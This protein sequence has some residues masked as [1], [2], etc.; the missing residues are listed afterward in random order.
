MRTLLE[1]DFSLLVV[2]DLEVAVACGTTTY[3]AAGWG[4]KSG[5]SV[6]CLVGFGTS[7]PMKGVVAI[8]TCYW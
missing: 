3:S 4:V 7:L 6:R 2:Y 8:F 1:A 5:V